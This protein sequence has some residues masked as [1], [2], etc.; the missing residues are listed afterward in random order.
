MLPSTFFDHSL[1]TQIVALFGHTNPFKTSGSG[2]QAF[3]YRVNSVYE[4]HAISVYWKYR[5]QQSAPSN[6]AS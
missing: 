1:Q 3:G 6:G 5:H 4:I 2:F